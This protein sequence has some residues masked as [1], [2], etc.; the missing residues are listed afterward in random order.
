V[1]NI[2]GNTWQITASSK[3]DIRADIFQFA[4]QNNLAVLTLKKTEQNLEDVFRELTK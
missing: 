4:V 1:K 3:K 2:S